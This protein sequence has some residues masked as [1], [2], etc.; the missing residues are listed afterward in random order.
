MIVTDAFVFIHLHKAGGS[1][2]SKLVL[3]LFPS[4]RRL[5]YHYPLASLPRRY[6]GLPVL[7]AVRSPWA[8]YVSYF[9]FQQRLAEAFEAHWRG[10]TA[11]EYDALCRA[12]V[13]PRNGIDLL[14]DTLCEAQ[15]AQFAAVTDQL[16]ELADN[17]ALLDRLA[18]TLPRERDRRGAYTPLQREGFRGMN[19]TQADLERLRGSDTGF[20][21]FLFR[22]M[23]GAGEGVFF[24]RQERLREDL[25]RFFAEHDIALPAHAREAVLCAPAQNVTPHAA[26]A[27]YYTPALARRVGQRERHLVERFG[28]VPPPLDP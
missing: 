20:Y 17:P 3:E 5:G 12:G 6:H 13:D 9:T 14:F 15:G 16:L 19:L 7:G 1:F 22:H 4:A 23:F 27:S 18:A 24:A 8:F 2:V 11:A 10:R 28:Y 25:L 26:C 21:S